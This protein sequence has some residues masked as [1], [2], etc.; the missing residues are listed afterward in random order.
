MAFEESVETQLAYIELK[1]LKEGEVCSYETLK[2][3]IGADPQ[4]GG[5]GYVMSAR[6]RV[7]KENE[8]VLQAETNV[9][10]R[11]LTAREVINRG[12]K[13]LSH[14]RRSTK[15]GL[16]RQIT[17]TPVE[18]MADLNNEERIQFHTQLS[19]MGILAH[20]MRP[21]AT[22]LIEEKVTVQN[23]RLDA[24]KVLELFSGRK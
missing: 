11:R 1:Q 12:G 3:A 24:G 19:H 7:E 9:G 18:R 15:S 6:K 14:I 10:I 4:S 17:I 23:G 20:I 8:C 13:D 2:Q 5:Y 21:K 16:R 22:K